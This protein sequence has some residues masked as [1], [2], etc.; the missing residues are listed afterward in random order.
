MNLF[1]PFSVSFLIT[2]FTIPFVIKLARRLN[3]V[4]DPNLRP[5]PAHIHTK[6][7]P[8]AGGLPI[9]IAITLTTLIFVPFDKHILGIL[10]GSLILLLTG[11]FDDYL[12]DFSPVKRLIFQF[13]SALVVVGSGVGITF[14]G[15]PFG[16]TLRLDEIVFQLNL[17]GLHNIIILADL[18]ALFW[19]VW[20]ENCLNWSTGVDGQMPGI[21]LAA[22]GTIG[23]LSSKLYLNGDP[24]QLYIAILSFITAGSAFGLLFFNWSP[25]KIFPGF[26]GSTILGFMIA[27]L[28]ILSGA[29]LATALLV[30]LIPAVDFFYTFF[31]RIFSRKSPF[32]GDQKHLHHMLLNKGFTHKQIAL[33]YVVTSALLGILATNLSSQG[34]VFTV[35]GVSV[36]VFG[37]ILWLHLFQKE[38][39][40]SNNNIKEGLN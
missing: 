2:L 26:S 30:L 31:R 15:N 4:D 32:L 16:G 23:L 17:F 38:L 18:F 21:A 22:A 28:S 6:I 1:I 13:V 10:V 34:K 11:L 20:I 37:G 12:H 14:V 24:H 19:I 40:Q 35:L 39:K 7:T 33:F 27:T 36:I 9:F 25:A 3:L 29:K 5:H 8:R